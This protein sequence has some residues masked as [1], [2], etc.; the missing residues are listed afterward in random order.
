MSHSYQ[1][2]FENNREWAEHK[3]ELDPDYFRRL[4]RS[5]NPSYLYI[6]CSDSRVAV[7]ELMGLEP[8]E[9]F[10]HRNVAN[11][12]IGMDLNVSSTIEYAVSHLKVKHIIICGHYN[13]GGIR[14]AMLPQDHG[15]ATSAM[16]TGCTRTNSMP[17]RTSISATTVWWS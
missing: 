16:S 12:V 10:V 8:G 7:E 2:I 15:C 11:L 3:K 6:G 4:S 5:Q 13:C 17:S 1:V 9:V 14:A